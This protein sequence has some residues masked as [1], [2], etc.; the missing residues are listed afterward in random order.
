[1]LLWS[2]DSDM[3]VV[4]RR[5]AEPAQL[6]VGIPVIGVV[7]EAD[8]QFLLQ[9]SA[10]SDQPLEVRLDTVL[11]TAEFDFPVGDPWSA[12]PHPG[13]ALVVPGDDGSYL[14]TARGSERVS[15]GYVVGE[16]RNHV[17]FREC[18]GETGCQ[19]VL[20]DVAA[21]ERTVLTE[22]V[23]GEVAP[24]ASPYWLS[25]DGTALARVAYLDAGPTVRFVEL[26]SG[27]STDFPV[28]PAAVPP[29]LAWAPDSSGLFIVAD[30][31]VVFRTRA[32]GA[33]TELAGLTGPTAGA[34]RALAVR[35]AASA[36][37]PEES[38]FTVPLAGPTGLD[39]VASTWDDDVI[40]I[41]VDA[42]TVVAQP[43]PPLAAGPVRLFAD[44]AG[45]T[46]ASTVDSPG[47][48]LDDGAVPV[49][50]E[51]DLIGGFVLPGPVAGTLWRDRTG[52]GDGRVAFDLIDVR[53][54]PLGPTVELEEVSALGSDGN[55]LLLLVAIGG[56]YS[57]SPAG[58]VR[59]T[60]GGLLASGPTA[61]YARECDEVL[62]CGVVRVDRATGERRPIDDPVLVGA[63]FQ[64]DA[65]LAGST[66]SPDGDVAFVRT[67]RNGLS[68]SFVDLAA[69][70]AVPAPG[71]QKS[72]SLV[73][74]ADGRFAA[75]L[76]G[77]R[78]QVFDRDAATLTPLTGLP[79]IRAFA[80]VR[81]VA[82]P[83]APIPF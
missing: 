81:P 35:P 58:A 26:A 47:F 17:L 75:Y 74:S 1:M 49:P 51:G 59:L 12:R 72:T 10:G 48:R 6:Q 45:V 80:V 16:G 76:S 32:T 21:G 28:D 13:G 23:D 68:W 73:W 20:V 3:I 77:D 31:A 64:T 63:P 82:D 41:D 22:L 54:A 53:G 71:P 2:R 60:T 69:G 78:L 14:L 7:A 29:M 70:T 18:A 38:S 42:G 11:R 52:G 5:D 67:S 34:A 46:L 83:P 65:D 57:V 43:G 50:I 36:R 9:P 55:G 33:G 56:F 25:P 39:L 66:V 44:D 4:L 62:A 19:L 30:G 79:A 24:G 15:A 27:A 40:E 8:D 37:A 61:V